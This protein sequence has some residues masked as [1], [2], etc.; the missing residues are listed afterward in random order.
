MHA[1]K[2]NLPMPSTPIFPNWPESP[3]NKKYSSQ[4]VACAL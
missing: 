1:G 4:G 3:K 2:E